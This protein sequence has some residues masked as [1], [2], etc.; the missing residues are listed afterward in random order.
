[1]SALSSPNQ[2]IFL[3]P[4]PHVLIVAAMGMIF[5]F[6]LGSVFVNH[7]VVSDFFL[8]ADSKADIISGTYILGFIFGVFIAGYVTYGSGRK[9]SII[10]SITVGSLSIFASLVAPNFSILLCSEL[11]I[12][13]SFGL[14]LISAFLY[15]CEI[16]PPNKRAL[17]LMMIPIGILVG[18]FF[19]FMNNDDFYE[20]PFFVFIIFL[21]IN[22]VLG[23]IAIVKLNESPRYLAL[24]GS[25][26]A[27]LSVL[28][29]LRHDMG[30]AA[31]ELAEINE[32]CRGESRGF[33]FFLQHTVYRRLLSYLCIMAFLFNM[34]GVI[35][36]PYILMD[37]ISLQIVCD[38][39]N[40]C[41]FS[42]NNNFVYITFITAFMGVILHALAI[43][44]NKRR[45]VLLY[46]FT[47][48]MLFLG[49]ATTTTLL[50]ITDFTQYTLFIALLLFIFFSFSSFLIFLVVISVE[51]MPIRG[52]E[53]GLA[54][55]FL[56]HGIGI[57]VAMHFYGPMLHRYGF[58]GLLGFTLACSLLVLYFC[59]LYLPHTGKLS[60]ENIENRIISADSFSEINQRHTNAN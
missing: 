6:D 12:G 7:N 1:M 31:R 45:I 35:I 16:M 33:E 37:N 46:S 32:C 21:G 47:I 10:S 50:P 36:I 27:A 15:T 5:G 28:F 42:L 19:A 11:V 55:I 58:T 30:T 52:R 4:L 17:A 43:E 57:L 26:D 22:I 44:R 24:I 40:Y 3:W 56:A 23:S 29:K 8:I 34:S 2:D 9:I 48:G 53:F 38:T 39:D 49:I 25:S 18:S 14:Y 41:Y 60:L 59:Y 13:F 51:L 54:A 20:H